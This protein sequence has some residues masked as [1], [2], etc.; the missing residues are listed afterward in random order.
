MLPKD[1]LLPMLVSTEFRC[2]RCP[3]PRPSF[4]VLRVSMSQTRRRMAPP[5][6]PAPAYSSFW[7]QQLRFGFLFWTVCCLLRS[8]VLPPHPLKPP[9]APH[10]FHIFQLGRPE[11]ERRRREGDGGPPREHHASR[12]P[13]DVETQPSRQ[14]RLCPRR[15]W[16]QEEKEDVLEGG[17][18]SSRRSL[19]GTQLAGGLRGSVSFSPFLSCLRA[20]VGGFFC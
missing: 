3:C 12:A 5:P 11:T 14:R 15:W 2:A 19:P 9:P 8:P 17:R 6:S 10:L 18:E 20:Y 13:R 4:D 1:S 7:F 16:Q